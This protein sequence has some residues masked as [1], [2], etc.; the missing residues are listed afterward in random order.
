[1]SEFPLDCLGLCPASLGPTTGGSARAVVQLYRAIGRGPVAQNSM[2]CWI[3]HHVSFKSN[4]V[5]YWTT[6]NHT[7]T[8]HPPAL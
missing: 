2:S 6:G 4:A 3:K 1:M 5:R 7:R 8:Y